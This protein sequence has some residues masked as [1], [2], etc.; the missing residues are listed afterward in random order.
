M[1]ALL[2][3]VGAGSA[4]S[5]LLDRVHA[6]A[7][8]SSRV[9]GSGECILVRGKFLLIFAED[10]FEEGS[11]SAVLFFHGISPEIHETLKA[12]WSVVCCCFAHHVV[13]SSHFIFVLK[14]ESATGNQ[15]L[16]SR[17]I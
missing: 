12:H 1:F 17:T 11:S 3:I 8:L 14:L 2:I 15:D 13:F 5:R 7:S 10:F 6:Q 4:Y 16:A 9:L